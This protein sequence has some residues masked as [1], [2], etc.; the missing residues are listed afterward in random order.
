MNVKM[1]IVLCLGVVSFAELTQVQNGDS[2][3]QRLRNELL[4]RGYNL[5][6]DELDRF[7]KRTGRLYYKLMFQ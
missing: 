4:T 6:A 2:L 3:D 7:D 1:F 5:G